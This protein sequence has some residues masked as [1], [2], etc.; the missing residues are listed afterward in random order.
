MT[1]T[2]R[3]R[4]LDLLALLLARRGG[5]A[6]PEVHDLV[7]GYAGDGDASQEAL[8]RKYLRD[9]AELEDAGV[10]FETRGDGLRVDLDSLYDAGGDP[11]FTAAE[12][13]VLAAAGDADFGSAKLNAVA[14][15]AR[16]KIAAHH[17]RPAPTAGE[18]LSVAADGIN[19]SADE[20]M[21]LA[22]ALRDRTA[23]R[24]W[25]SAQVD[26]DDELRELEPWAIA[27]HRSRLYL[28]GHDR[29]RGAARVFRL[30]NVS[31]PAARLVDVD[32]RP[33]PSPARVPRAAAAEVEALI[34]R[35]HEMGMGDLEL[36]VDVVPGT[37]GDVTRRAEDLG[38]GRWR[39]PR[40]G[41]LEARRIALENAGRLAVVEPAA[42]RD[43]VVAA[44]RELAAA[45]G[46]DADVDEDEETDDAR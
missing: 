10:R 26:R 2:N 12:L 43:E 8:E 37:C 40:V 42:L 17:G 15:G 6:G 24:F 34:A 20:L 30:A 44:L 38:G 32:G 18:T 27:L 31:E 13:E 5:V 11:G 29:D 46:G 45:A 22:A 19:L 28:V 7:P 1:T 41:A 16:R 14:A 4:Q 33:A 23:V 35:A 21:V 25:Y 39:L 9:R 3:I 36:V